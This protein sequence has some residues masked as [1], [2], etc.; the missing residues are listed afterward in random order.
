MFYLF[1]FAAITPVL[2]TLIYRKATKA[3]IILLCAITLLVLFSYV[4]VS[5]RDANYMA[6]QRAITETKAKAPATATK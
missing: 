6:T 1:V 4:L 3:T 2:L 5:F